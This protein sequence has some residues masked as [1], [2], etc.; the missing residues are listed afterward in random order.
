MKRGGRK[1]LEKC[2]ISTLSEVLCLPN[3]HNP[4]DYKIM[5]IGYAIDMQSSCG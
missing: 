4:V 3:I 1:C 2:L 5:Y